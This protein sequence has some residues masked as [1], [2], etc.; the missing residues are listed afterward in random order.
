MS[1]HCMQKRKRVKF[2]IMRPQ[3]WAYIALSKK[4][5]EFKGWTSMF[6]TQSIIFEIDRM[7]YASTQIRGLDKKV[8]N[9]CL[10]GEIS[11]TEKYTETT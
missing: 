10:K 2:D 5:G 1:S 4:G 6:F 8:W 3:T 11:F 7:N 9:N